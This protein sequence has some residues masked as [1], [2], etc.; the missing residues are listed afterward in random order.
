MIVVQHNLL[1]GCWQALTR[2][3]IHAA[4]FEIRLECSSQFT[5]FTHVW[6]TG[7]V[8]GVPN[9]TWQA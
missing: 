6:Q 5:I 7:Q 3:S 4:P 9:Q 2:H 1:F 8:K